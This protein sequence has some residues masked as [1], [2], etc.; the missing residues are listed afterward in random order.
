[1]IIL[2]SNINTACDINKGLII[3]INIL[4]DIWTITHINYCQYH[5]ICVLF[6]AIIIHDKFAIFALS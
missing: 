2:L 6:T 4:Y 1:M 3:D 5:L